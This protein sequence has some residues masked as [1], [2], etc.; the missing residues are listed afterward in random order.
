MQM[1]AKKRW[2]DQ[3]LT[4]INRLP[5]RTSFFTNSA[6]QVSLNGSWAFKYLTA[7]EYS[8]EG[9]EKRDYDTA[10][11]D[12]IE[13]PSCWQ[14]KGYDHMHYTDVLY[15]FPLNPPYVPTE[16]PTGI[17]KRSFEIP[18]NWM[19]NDTILR[20][21]GVDSAYDVWVNGEHVG[22]SKV[23][24]LPAEFDISSYINKGENQVTVRVYKWSDGTYLEDQDMWWFSGI[25]RNVSL[26]SAPKA[27]IED[28][29]IH[30]DLDDSY[31]TGL[32]D[33]QIRLAGEGTLK[34]VLADAEGVTAASGEAEAGESASISA[35]LESVRTWTAET[36]YLYT[37]TL[38][39]E[40]NGTVSHQVSY[41]LGF[42]RVE[43]K[44]NVFT[45]NGKAVL[46]NGVNHHDYS[47]EG[48]RTV[49]LEVMRQD[50]L[51][52]KQ[53]NIN[54]IRFSHY[55]SIE[56]IYDFCDEYGMYVIDEADLECHGFEW[57]HVYDMITDDPSWE[58]A[59]VDRAVRMVERDYNH[60]SIIMW[61]L[62]NESY[63]GVNFKKEAEAIR[64]MDSSRLI[65]YE[66]DF[67]AEI[68][69]VYSTMY[70]RLKGLKEIGETKM[71][72]N[73]P[74][75][76]CEYSHAMG[77]GPGC[78]ADYQKL[79]RTYDRLQGGFIWEWYDHGIKTTDENGTVTYKY[80]GNYGD[81]PTNG[82][83]CIDGLLMPDRTPSPGL[84][85]YKQVICPVW[86]ERLGET[87]DLFA[88][89]NYYDFKTLDGIYLECAVTDGKETLETFTIDSLHTEP[90]V[91]EILTIPHS[92]VEWKDNRDY[93]LN[94]SVREKKET[95]W[96]PAGHELGHYQFPL[97]EK[98][99]VSVKREE[100]PVSVSETA[101]EVSISCQ[102]VVYSFDKV[103]GVLSSMKKGGQ[104]LVKR[105]PVLTV[106][107]ADIDNDMYKVNDW[108]NNYFISRGMEEMEYMTVSSGQNK[109]QV[110][111]QKHF[112]CY[113]QVWGFK[114]A[115]VYTV[116]GD[117][118]METEL[119]GT[120]IRNP[121]FEPEFLPR[122]GV[123]MNVNGAFR[124]VAWYGMGPGENY[125]DSRQAAVMG[126]YETDV[127]GMHTNYVMPQENGHRENVRWVS[128]TDEKEGL[129]ITSRG[130]V[131][132]NVHDY[133]T[134]ALRSAAH[135]CKIKKQDDI[136]LNLDWKH[137]GLGSN[138]CGQEQTE[139]CKVRI[140]DF[141]MS[142]ALSFTEREKAEERAFTVF[143]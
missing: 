7:P 57:A 31:T 131:G 40:Q 52:M 64:A 92:A 22:F 140:E 47:P 85:E 103:H 130:G 71:K 122:I 91:E 63:F 139:E 109:A 43:V 84:V 75:I 5:G 106:D 116:Y 11:W 81:F 123:E 98:K 32:F 76:H 9:F 121:E 86:M 67:E 6:E 8:P 29:R 94:I 111:I 53:H 78:L 14:L 73:R 23:S 45:V 35:R 21:E 137:S 60:P 41:R 83:F 114:L 87:G 69:D 143:C 48:G 117:G 80:G 34:W 38:S 59:Y 125:C 79:Y 120:A 56:A 51:L 97:S 33:A 88:V 108:K 18:E 20:F 26:I 89:K 141:A 70:S 138:S 16:N 128:L 24:R 54:A 133:T 126:V 118:S 72:H 1:R 62:G 46:I 66:G 124:H 82:N 96:A 49:D 4:G 134:E 25:Y 115:Y 55:P 19:E 58:N 36:P 77:N 10:G 28:C 68:T 50:V 127:D 102:D 42:R 113:N 65:H 3:N 44:G 132:I 61:S 93:Y 90:G 104:E 101:T 136:V 17:Y 105:G 100:L 112:G 74:H 2:E 27:R 129:L 110:Y 37:L 142:F 99:T 12:T 15:L 107:R 119:H 135:P 13:V 95:A 30:A 39:M